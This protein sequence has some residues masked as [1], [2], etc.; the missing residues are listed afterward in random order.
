MATPDISVSDTGRRPTPTNQ[1]RQIDTGAPQRRREDNALLLNGARTTADLTGAAFYQV[2]GE[3]DRFFER[4]TRAASGIYRIAVEAPSDATPGKDFALAVRVPKRSGTTVRANRHAVA[5]PPTS[6][7]APTTAAAGPKPAV[8]GESGPKPASTT[9][10]GLVAPEEQIRRAIASGRALDGFPMTLDST[11]RRAD[12]PAQVAIDVVITVGAGAKP[13][14]ATMFGLVDAAGAIR[15]SSR[16]L[17]DSTGYRLAFRVPVA[18]GPY[19]LRVAAADAS[20]VVAAIESGVDA[21]LTALGPLQASGI[22]VQ[23]LGGGGR[24]VLAGIDLYPAAGAAPADLVVKM[25]LLSP[26]GDVVV[27][28]VIVPEEDHDALRAEAE[29]AL[30]RL[31]SGVY[32]VRVTVLSGTT[33]LGTVTR[34][35]R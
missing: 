19:K 4:V 8:A 29:F 14:V 9:A 32:T 34:Q 1:P 30:D 13:P 2:T 3:P 35:I 27:E 33:V 16:T 7:T 21:R 11:L 18:P 22:G 15:T 25:A 5:V 12:D 26:S 20:G 23:P 31:P 28:R 17:A 24:R 6:T 10:G